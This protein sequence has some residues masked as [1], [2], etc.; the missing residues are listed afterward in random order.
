M[1]R[2]GSAKWEGG[3]KDG[4]GTVSTESGVLAETQYSFSTRFETG[5]WSNTSFR[6]FRKWSLII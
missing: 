5:K 2:K 1:K 6:F 4:H 3:I